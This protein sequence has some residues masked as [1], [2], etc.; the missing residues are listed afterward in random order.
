MEPVDQVLHPTYF[1]LDDVPTETLNIHINSNRMLLP[2][3]QSLA[4]VAQQLENLINGTTVPDSRQ[5][6]DI[7]NL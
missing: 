3:Q 2:F 7:A 5:M 6:E 4:E 1:H